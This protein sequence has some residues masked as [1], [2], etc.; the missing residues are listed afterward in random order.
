VGDVTPML[1]VLTEQRSFDG[2]WVFERK[3]DGERCLAERSGGG[4]RLLSRSQQRLEGTYPELVDAL[5][6]QPLDDLLVDGEVVAFDGDQT[7]F[8]LLQQR[9]GIH[10]AARARRSPVRVFYYLFDVLRLGRRELGAE[11]LLTRK[12]LLRERLAFADPLRLL[13]H[14]SGDSERLYSQACAAGWE[15]L[16][17]K[18]A[19]APYRRGRSRDWLKLK[20]V[21]AQ[22]LVIGGYTDPSGSRTGFGALLVGYHDAQGG[23]RYAGKVGTGYTHALLR[24]L[25]ARL[26]ALEQDASPFVERVPARGVHWV[27]PELVAEVG[28]SELTTTGRLRHPRFLGLRSDKPAAEVTLERP[29][30]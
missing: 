22:E 9:L 1:A 7:S 17:A 25:G 15:G 19:D 5:L 14:E 2:A 23:L 11:P 10:D 8:A 30:P 26:A 20:C 29:Q 18:R 21:Q 27:R 28:Y 16:I 6:A 12:A 13:E 24:E 4:V 3:L